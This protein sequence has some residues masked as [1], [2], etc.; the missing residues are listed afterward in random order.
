MGVQDSDRLGSE[1]PLHAVLGQGTSKQGK[2][3]TEGCRMISFGAD[4]ARSNR[5][6]HE[7]ATTVVGAY[8]VKVSSLDSSRN[9][10]GAATRFPSK[11]SRR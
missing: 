7:L 6:L 2:R 5:S 1:Q 11:P 10:R 8:K 9:S 3:R 4:L